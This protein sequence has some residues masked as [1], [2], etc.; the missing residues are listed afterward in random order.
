[1]QA[2]SAH[3]PR[4]VDL[5]YHHGKGD[6]RLSQAKEEEVNSHTHTLSLSLSLS[7]CI[8]LSNNTQVEVSTP[9]FVEP[10]GLLFCLATP[11][12]SL[13]DA[14]ASLVSLAQGGGQF[15][16]TGAQTVFDFGSSGGSLEDVSFFQ[17]R[18]QVL[19]ANRPP[20]SSDH[21]IP[22]PARNAQTKAT[23]WEQNALEHGTVYDVLGTDEYFSES[24]AR[25]RYDDLQF[26]HGDALVPSTPT[27]EGDSANC[28]LLTGTWKAGTRYALELNVS[29]PDGVSSPLVVWHAP[30]SYA[31]IDEGHTRYAVRGSKEGQ[32]C[33]P[34]QALRDWGGAELETYDAC[35]VLRSVV[36]GASETEPE[37]CLADLRTKY[38]ADPLPGVD[39]HSAKVNV[40]RSAG[41][42][43][44]SGVDVSTLT[45]S[46]CGANEAFSANFGGECVDCGE[47]SVEY[48]L[49]TGKPLSCSCA[50]TRERRAIGGPFCGRFRFPLCGGQA[51]PFCGVSN[52]TAT[53]ARD[54]AAS[55]CSFYAEKY[56]DLLERR[57]SALSV[58]H[59][60]LEDFLELAHSFLDRDDLYAANETFASSFAFDERHGDSPTRRLG[61][62]PNCYH[63]NG[64]EFEDFETGQR[65][66]VRDDFFDAVQ[67]FR[68]IGFV[69]HTKGYPC[70]A[71]FS[72]SDPFR[73]AYGSFT[74][75]V[76]QAL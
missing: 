71:L 42:L 48:D 26:A 63:C 69:L 47:G 1:M 28:V 45:N 37:S 25:R 34:R 2:D 43:L 11:G 12:A 19:C 4:R 74:E 61:V 53:S 75:E 24:Y 21:P 44:E 51:T 30:I 35:E 56:G 16:Q 27:G 72:A 31:K 10:E 9:S 76:C 46:T 15:D 67:V 41:G 54:V 32:T 68:L 3:E 73:K 6:P 20:P 23:F 29:N 55:V 50:S 60:Y 17:V 14:T 58:A 65:S 40:F 70:D 52:S 8:F 57:A 5:Q 33:E 66:K 13:S 64:G 36:G 62:K 49:A 18:D 39:Q 7:L 22:Y 38:L 59:A